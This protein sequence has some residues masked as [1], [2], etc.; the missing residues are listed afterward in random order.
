[1]AGLGRIQQRFNAA[2]V[3]V[4]ALAGFGTQ[5][6]NTRDMLT[7]QKGHPLAAKYVKSSNPRANTPGRRYRG[8]CNGQAEIR[9]RWEKLA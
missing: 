7:A 2:L 6:A 9:R 4:L 5:H 3:T 1:M 8:Y